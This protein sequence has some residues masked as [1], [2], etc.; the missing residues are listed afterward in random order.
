MSLR[1]K[2]VHKAMNAATSKWNG[3]ALYNLAQEMSLAE[4][5]STFAELQPLLQAQ[6][7]QRVDKLT[8][9]DAPACILDTQKKFLE[10]AKKGSHARL[11]PL[12]TRI[13]KLKAPI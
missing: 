6:L 9:M 3:I 4:A 12:K 10:S 8:S 11:S 2:Y 13:K 7:Q 5:E 1:E